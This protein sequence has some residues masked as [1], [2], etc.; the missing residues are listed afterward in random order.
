MKVDREGVGDIQNVEDEESE[1]VEDEAEDSLDG[2]SKYVEILFRRGVASSLGDL[3]MKGS[4]D[5]VLSRW[6]HGRP[7]NLMLDNVAQ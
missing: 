2:S 3:S 4:F 6:A 1:L 7:K 5:G